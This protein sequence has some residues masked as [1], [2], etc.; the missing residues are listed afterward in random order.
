G[1]LLRYRCRAATV[2]VRQQCVRQP[3]GRQQQRQ[4]T[5]T[6]QDE[7]FAIT[8]CRCLRSRFLSPCLISRHDKI[9]SPVP[10]HARLHELSALI[11]PAMTYHGLADCQCLA[12]IK[13][14]AENVLTS[15]PAR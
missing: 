13:P 7:E 4:Q 3:T 8:C 11:V 15:A 14:S 2:T 5:D 10:G 9:P 12:R 1:R 6:D